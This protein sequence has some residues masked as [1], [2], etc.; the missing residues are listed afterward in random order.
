MRR[1]PLLEL[2]VSE[3]KRTIGCPGRTAIISLT[4]HAIIAIIRTPFALSIVH[5]VRKS[6]ARFRVCGGATAAIVWVIP[7]FRK[8]PEKTFRKAE[9]MS[10]GNGLGRV[11]G[12]FRKSI[13][14]RERVPP[15][16][17][18]R[19]AKLARNR[20]KGSRIGLLGQSSRGGLFCGHRLWGIVFVGIV[21]REPI[22]GGEI[23]RRTK[24]RLPQLEGRS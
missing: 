23:P 7:E 3:A 15:G 19:L 14:K 11:P 16:R 9:K 10:V 5:P 1:E 18:A 17:L 22:T 21:P 13:L 2:S 4:D 6:H 12:R 20:F 8:F 24:P